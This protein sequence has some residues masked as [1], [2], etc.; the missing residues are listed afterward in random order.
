MTIAH[1]YEAYAILNRSLNTKINNKILIECITK[2]I[3]LLIPLTPHIANEIL[4][5]L[6]CKNKYN[7]PTI[8]TDF[9]EEIKFAVQING[10]TRDIITVKKKYYPRGYREND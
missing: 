5:L 2:I 1:F 9:V 6:K 8:K 3:K 10:K 7:W 4:D